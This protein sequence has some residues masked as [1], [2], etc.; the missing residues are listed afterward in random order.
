MNGRMLDR[1]LTH[2]VAVARYG[3]FT[4]AAAKVGISQSGITKSVADLEAQL[5]HSLFYRTAR[6]AM[7]TEAGRE[8]VDRAVRLLEDANLLLTGKLEGGDPYAQS[9]RIGVCPAS[10]EW[11]LA[12]PLLVMLSRHPSVRFEIVAGT[13]ERVIQLLRTGAI[14]VAVGF[15]DAFTEWNEFR[16]ERIA[17]IRGLFFV[18]K[19]HPIL[20][21][22]PVTPAV[23]ARYNFVVPSDSRPYGQVIRSLFDHTDQWQRHLH[24]VD[25][26]P[27]VRRIVALTD[28]IGVTTH[29]YA[30]SAAFKAKF[31]RVPGKSPLP[32]S[33][34][35]CAYRSRWEPTRSLRAFLRI[36]KDKLPDMT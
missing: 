3:S 14:D 36:M 28:T 21:E 19:G 23:L 31:E 6:G 33:P 10:I 1:R 7:L 4:K 24:V 26:F 5:G 2:V 30:S 29:D 32:Q 34:L 13:F 35:C 16:R 11:L 12:E 22:A 8:F 20:K 27:I 17:T 9:L 18:R 15:E 25:Y